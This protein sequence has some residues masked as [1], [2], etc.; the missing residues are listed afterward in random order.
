ME[1]LVSAVHGTKFLS[2]FHCLSLR[3]MGVLNEASLCCGGC[4]ELCKIFSGI[5]GLYPPNVSKSSSCDHQK[6]L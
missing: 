4:V 6:C 3:T 1:I 2:R 5:S